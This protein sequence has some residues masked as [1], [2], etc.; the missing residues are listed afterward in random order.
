[1]SIKDRQTKILLA[2][3][4]MSDENYRY[5]TFDVAV[6]SIFDLSLNRKTISMFNK[7]VKSGLIET[8]RSEV[9]RSDSYKLTDSG[10]QILTLNFPVFRYTKSQWDNI[11]R[12]LSYQIPEELKRP[13]FLC[14]DALLCHGAYHTQRPYLEATGDVFLKWVATITY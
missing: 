10:F 14:G 8:A 4:L 5:I 6:T 12:I 7:L 9:D 1:M 13:N 11:W 3:L 2:L